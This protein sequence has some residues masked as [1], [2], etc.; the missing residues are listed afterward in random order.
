MVDPVKLDRLPAKGSAAVQVEIEDYQMCP[1]YSALVL[2]NVNV[3]PS[4]L[5]L[6]ARLQRLG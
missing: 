5:W 1:R 3:G 6:Q 2:D 4:P